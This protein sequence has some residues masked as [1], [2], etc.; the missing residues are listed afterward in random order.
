MAAQAVLRDRRESVVLREREQMACESPKM[1]TARNQFA[2]EP[3]TSRRGGSARQ[4]AHATRPQ[5]LW[6]Q[7]AQHQRDQR[8]AVD[9]GGLPRT[10]M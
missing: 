5:P 7:R 6:Q 4:H 10:P 3:S 2:E 8:A 9:A 1:M